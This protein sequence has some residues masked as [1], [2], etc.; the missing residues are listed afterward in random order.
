M[1][2]N[3]TAARLIVLVIVCLPV[4]IITFKGGCGPASAQIPDHGGPAARD[5]S[6]ATPLEQIAGVTDKPGVTR[7][8]NIRGFHRLPACYSLVVSEAQREAIY[9]IQDEFGP[10]IRQLDNELNALRGARNA[11]IEAIITDADR[12]KLAA[13]KAMPAAKRPRAER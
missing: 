11:R 2:Q 5:I 10:K 8:D 3:R 7:K 13:I 9:R 4:L 1:N 6:R 12:A